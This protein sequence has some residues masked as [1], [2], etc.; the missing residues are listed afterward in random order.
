MLVNPSKL[1]HF[2]K[3][4]PYFVDRDEQTHL[5]LRKLIEKRVHLRAPIARTRGLVFP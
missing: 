5:V 2:L 3:I 4:D 1:S